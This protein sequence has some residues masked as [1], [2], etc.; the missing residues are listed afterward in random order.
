MARTLEERFWN[1]VD[2]RGRDECWMWTG[3]KV[4]QGYGMI[5]I[6]NK[7]VYAHRV[8]LELHQGAF[9]PALRVLHRCDNPPCVN[10][11]HLVLGTQRE[12]VIDMMAK[13]RRSQ[14]KLTEADVLKIRSMWKGSWHGN[15]THPGGSNVELAKLFDVSPAAI[16]DIVH[17][18]RWKHI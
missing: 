6:K 13:G 14:S 7:G 11:H 2:R 15:N 4:K 3:T 10:P 9:D 18:R 16:S 8:S 1:F 17:R 12:N 5:R